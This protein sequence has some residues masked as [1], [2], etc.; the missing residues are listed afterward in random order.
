MIPIALSGVW[1]LLALCAATIS[2]PTGARFHR[3]PFALIISVRS[4]WWKRTK[5]VRAATAGSIIL[6]G[7]KLENNDIDHE[8]V[9]V[10]QYYRE[11]FIHPFLYFYQSIRYGYRNNKYEIEAYTRTKSIYKGSAKVELKG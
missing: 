8:L 7:P 5:G 4:F 6:C 10:E 3:R 1:S 2:I 11:P 9:H